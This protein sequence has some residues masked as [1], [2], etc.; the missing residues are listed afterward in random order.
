M[1][2]TEKTQETEGTWELILSLGEFIL[3]PWE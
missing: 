3:S 1:E 2:D